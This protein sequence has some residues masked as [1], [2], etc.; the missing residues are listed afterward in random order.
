MEKQKYLHS[1]DGKLGILQIFGDFS[2]NFT[3]FEGI[4]YEDIFYCLKTEKKSGNRNIYTTETN[5]QRRTKI[6]GEILGTFEN[7]GEKVV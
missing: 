6:S 7:F 3:I 5:Q 2:M 4:F 1:F